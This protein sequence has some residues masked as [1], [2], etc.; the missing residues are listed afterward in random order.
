M[1]NAFSGPGN[2]Y[3]AEAAV[4]AIETRKKWALDYLCRMGVTDVT[5]A[6][7]SAP[8]VIEYLEQSK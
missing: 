4:D 2:R 3:L 8:F 7:R 6:L 1:N 5:E